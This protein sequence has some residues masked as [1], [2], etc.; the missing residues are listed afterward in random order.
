LNLQNIVRLQ[1]EKNSF[2]NENSRLSRTVTDITNEKDSIINQKDILYSENEKLNFELSDKNSIISNLQNEN[3]NLRSKNQS[4][5]SDVNYWKNN[6]SSS[7]SQ[8]YYTVNVSQAY[9]YSR[10]AD[11][12]T[13]LNCVYKQGQT[14]GVYY[15]YNGYGL[16]IGGYVKMSD[17]SK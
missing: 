9:C 8:T 4:L 13:Q 12:F 3:S 10:C 7:P 17:L 2:A 14:V 11:N 15:Q 1:N 16:T 5:T 6:T